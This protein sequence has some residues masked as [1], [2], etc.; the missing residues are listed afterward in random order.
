MK[1]GAGWRKCLSLTKPQQL[2][3]GIFSLSL[4]H[5]SE[6]G[7]VHGTQKHK[8][9][10]GSPIVFSLQMLSFVSSFVSHSLTNKLLCA[11]QIRILCG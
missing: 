5:T 3:L 10:W 11:K 6:R 2:G 1:G 4:V 7:L 9:L 8:V